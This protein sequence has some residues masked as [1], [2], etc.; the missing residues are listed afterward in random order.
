MVIIHQWGNGTILTDMNVDC[1]LLILKE[2]DFV[3]LINVAEVDEAYS[4]LAANVFKRKFALKIIELRET[5]SKNEVVELNDVIKIEKFNMISKVFN[6]F[7]QFISKVKLIYGRDQKYQSKQVFELVSHYSSTFLK[8]YIESYDEFLL[9]NVQKPFYNAENVSFVGVFHKLGSESMK[10]NE[11]FPNMRQLSLVYL[12]VTDPSSIH[13]YFPYLKYLYVSFL[14]A[15]QS[16]TDNDIECLINK[17]P[18]IQSLSIYNGSMKFF[19]FVSENMPNL[20][21]LSL[22]W[23]FRDYLNDGDSPIH[24]KTVKKLS[25]KYTINRFARNVTFDQLQELEFVCNPD[26]PDVWIDFLE[27]NTNLTKLSITNGEIYKIDLT[28][29]TS[30][31]PDLVEVSFICGLDIDIESIL[32]FLNLNTK[33]EKLNLKCDS[34]WLFREARSQDL[35]TQIGWKVIQNPNNVLF[36]KLSD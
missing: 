12:H 18:Q 17:N 8:F 34:N 30:I 14:R 19:K 1:Q 16:F 4:A 32:K 15:K 25:I 22:P 31:L 6:H 28:K 21:T 20:K 5:S 2:L 36:E 26:F 29:I 24:F 7:G 23:K 27:K 3:S 10:L 35:Q 13:L 33:L 11:M 9:Q